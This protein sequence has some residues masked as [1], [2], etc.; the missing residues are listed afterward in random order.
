MY[1]FANRCSRDNRI[2][3][4]LAVKADLRIR[5]WKSDTPELRA[6]SVNL[7][8]RGIFFVT[9]RLF[10]RGEA[11]EVFLQMPEEI[12]GEPPTE[13]RCTG[14]VVHV[15]S[16]DGARRRQGVGVRFDCYEVSRSKGNGSPE[17]IFLPSRFG[18]EIEANGAKASSHRRI[19]F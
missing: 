19:N 3:P 7:S 13:W 10:Q 17:D 8:E 16:V 6:E 18:L 1:T 9:D 15:Q 14:L 12:T 11:V 2:T 5:I 4:R